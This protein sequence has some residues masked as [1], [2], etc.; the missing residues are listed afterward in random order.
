ML[1]SFAKDENGGTAITYGLIAALVAIA[2][3][4]GA[5]NLGGQMKNTLNT[6]STT[7]KKG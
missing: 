7:M 3:I 2:I 1:R 5:K 6:A 4:A